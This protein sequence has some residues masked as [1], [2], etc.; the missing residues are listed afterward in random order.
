MISKN[1]FWANLKENNKRRIWL[2]ILSVLGFVIMFPSMVAICLSRTFSSLEDYVRNGSVGLEG[3]RQFVREMMLERMRY[4]LGINDFAWFAIGALAIISAIQGFS[5]L[6][7]RQKMDFYMGMP[8]KRKNRFFIIWLNG[9]LVY[10]IP[11]LLGLIVCGIVGAAYGAVNPIVIKEMFLAYG[12]HLCYFLGMYHLGLLAVML[13]GNV[14]VTFC[15][16][17]V[18]L[19]YEL[20]ARVVIQGYMDLFFKFYSDRGFSV[21]PALSPVAILDHYFTGRT[22]GEASLLLTVIL[23]LVF[24]LVVGGISYVLYLRRPAETAGKA[25]VFPF[26]CPWVKL[27]ITVLV[28]MLAGVAVSDLAGYDPRYYG[29]RHIGFVIFAMVLSLLIS[30]CLMQ[31]IYEF[32]IRGILHKKRQLLISGAV[33]ALLFCV[34]RFDLLGYDAYLPDTEKIES[35]ALITRES[36]GYNGNDY[37]DEDL[38]TYSKYNYVQANMSLTDV[39][40]VNKLMKLSM[41]AAEKY[42]SLNEMLT[43]ETRE[44]YTMEVTFRLKNNREIH[45]RIFVDVKDSETVEILDRIEASEEYLSG[46]D[47]AFSPVI[48]RVLADENNDVTLFYNNGVNNE[49]LNSKEAAE[50]LELYRKDML[51]A[52]FSSLS[53]SFPVGRVILNITTIK[54]DGTMRARKVNLDMQMN[55]Y[56]FF[57]GCIQYLSQKGCYLDG[58][59]DPADVER[60]QVANYHYDLQREAQEAAMNGVAVESAIAVDF[61]FVSYATYTGER[62][63]KLLDYLY[64]TELTNSYWHTARR[65]DSNYSVTVFLK[66]DGATVGDEYTVRCV[67]LKGEVPDFVAAD[68]SYK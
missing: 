35:A 10:L 68:T 17:L 31:V 9:I 42:G 57:D 32:D 52:D 20:I 5:Y 7:S 16:V 62:I 14:I 65:A 67:F 4:L 64:P 22:T 51:T 43:D 26:S 59:F 50:F 45:R 6:Y 38:Q 66:A 13:T 30:G 63:P 27:L 37:F 40:A 18:F 48:N 11:Y 28:S 25:M 15:G 34:F 44:W 2:W 33:T 46:S 56:P 24:A 36:Y 41:D 21:I 3:A 39:G 8:I 54:E 23:L 58:Y 49:H 12:L 60:I 55:I 61:D 29:D 47:M 53:T 19:L 1:S